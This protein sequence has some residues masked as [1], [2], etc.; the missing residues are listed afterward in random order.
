MKREQRLRRSAD[1][2]RVR[3]QAPRAWPHPLLVLYATPNELGH[4]RVGVTVGKRVGRAAARN[5]VRRRIHEALRPRYPDLRPGHDLVLVARPP[6]AQAPWAD[7]R[8]AVETVLGR[9]GLWVTVR[10]PEARAGPDVGTS[11]YTCPCTSA[12][13]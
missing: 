3:E 12:T 5:R 11:P 8:Q 4:T 13:A 1:F 7:L 6:S 10:R 2:Q 9:A